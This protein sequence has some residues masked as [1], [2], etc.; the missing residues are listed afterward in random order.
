MV[1]TKKLSKSYL[2]HIP[3]RHFAKNSCISL[4]LGGFLTAENPE[5]RQRRGAAA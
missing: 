1:K 2:N 3:L 4:R 5:K